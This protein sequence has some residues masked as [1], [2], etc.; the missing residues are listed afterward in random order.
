MVGMSLFLGTGTIAKADDVYQVIVKKQEEKKKTRWSLSEW[1]ETRDRMRLMDLWLAIH[2][3]SP[4]EFYLGGDYHFGGLKSDTPSVS[5]AYGSIR[6]YAAAFASI[7]GLEGQYDST[8][9]RKLGIFHVR[10]FG[11]HNQSTHITLQTGLRSEAEPENLR[12]IFAGVTAAFYFH[13]YFGIEG[14][15]RNYFASVNSV[16]GVKT[17]G[18]RYEGGAFVDFKFTRVYGTY[19]YELERVRGNPAQSNQTRSGVLAGVKLFF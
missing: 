7:F 10:I 1:L 18:T 12:H 13:R 16:N 4:Y 17:S 8:A 5:S 3:P 15:Y 2:S 14:L 9:S 19:F 6:G 11:F